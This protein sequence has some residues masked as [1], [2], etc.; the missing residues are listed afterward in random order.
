MG[1]KGWIIEISEETLK[2]LRYLE[3]GNTLVAS[4]LEELAST[5]HGDTLT[6]PQIDVSLY[7]TRFFYLTY[8]AV[9]GVLHSCQLDSQGTTTLH[10]PQLK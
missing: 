5:V 8:L 1:G 6:T 9:I 4:G 10:R 3:G 2:V 7:L